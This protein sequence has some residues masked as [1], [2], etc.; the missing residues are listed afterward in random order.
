MPTCDDSHHQELEVG[1][2]LFRSDHILRWKRNSNPTW[3]TV[4]SF[5]N[6]KNKAAFFWCIK[7]H[8]NMKEK[9]KHKLL[10]PFL[11]HKMK[12]VPIQYWQ[13]RSCPH[14]FNGFYTLFKHPASH[15]E[16]KSSFSNMTPAVCTNIGYHPH[17]SI[18]NQSIALCYTVCKE[19]N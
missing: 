15:Y 17:A 7:A 4:N 2:Y 13:L 11:F 8:K 9:R 12:L 1:D 18:M 19:R 5:S 3:E 10:T 6:T 16:R 14:G